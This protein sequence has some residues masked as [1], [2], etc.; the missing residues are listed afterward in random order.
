MQVFFFLNTVIS[1]VNSWTLPC[2]TA[3][4]KFLSPCQKVLFN[5]PINAQIPDGKAYEYYD[6]N[7]LWCKL[8]ISNQYDLYN[9]QN[10][11]RETPSVWDRSILECLATLLKLI[12]FLLITFLFRSPSIFE[13][14]NSSRQSVSVLSVVQWLQV[15]RPSGSK[16]SH[17]LLHFFHSHIPK[18]LQKNIYTA[19]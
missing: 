12:S 19:S 4:I 2:M 10:K 6:D 16:C 9:R 5:S 8:I 17:S 7:G 15:P 18:A 14:W 3:G 1:Y 11:I 13:T